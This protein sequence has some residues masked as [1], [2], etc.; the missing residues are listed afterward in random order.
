MGGGAAGKGM[1]AGGAAFV[2]LE[3]VNT[4]GGDRGTLGGADGGAYGGGIEGG[5]MAFRR[6][7]RSE[8]AEV[9]VVGK[10]S[11][12]IASVHTPFFPNLVCMRLKGVLV[13]R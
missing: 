13:G 1:C 3:G 6:G 2:S 4:G 11:S 12:T 8:D 10:H 5:G 9:N 7:G